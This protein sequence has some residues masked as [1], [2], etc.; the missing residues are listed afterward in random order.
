M[1]DLSKKRALTIAEA[2][3]Y[4]CYSRG[5]IEGWIARG[6]LPYEEPPGRGTGNHRFR[7]IRR[8]DLDTL[9]DSYYFQD[10]DQHTDAQKN[11]ADEMVLLSKKDRK[12]ERRVD[13]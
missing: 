12:I 9:L 11:E 4:S 7:K 5:T 3:R 1:D 8:A 10:T 2:T 6:L 13:L